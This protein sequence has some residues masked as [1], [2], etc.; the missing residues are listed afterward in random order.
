MKLFKKIKNQMDD[1]DLES[2]KSKFKKMDPEMYDVMMFEKG[3]GFDEWI[4]NVFISL[5]KNN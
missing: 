4:K 3:D 5:P 2:F 1:L